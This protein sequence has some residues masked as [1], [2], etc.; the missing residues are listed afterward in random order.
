MVFRILK[1]SLDHWRILRDEG[2]APSYSGVRVAIRATPSWFNIRR[3][4]HATKS[5]DAL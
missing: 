1:Q 4:D 5:N 3:S 2:F